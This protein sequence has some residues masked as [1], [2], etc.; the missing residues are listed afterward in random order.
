V[1]ARCFCALIL[2]IE[3][4]GDHHVFIHNIAK[5]KNAY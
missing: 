2:D 3:P 1:S 5:C 4:H